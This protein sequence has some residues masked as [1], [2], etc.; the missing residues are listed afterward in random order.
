MFFSKSFGYAV[1]SILYI[2][3]AKEQQRYVQAEDV[4]LQLNAPRHF[5][6]KILKMLAKEQVLLS[7]KGPNGGFRLHQQAEQM[8]LLKI[9]FLT[10]GAKPFEHCVLRV[11]RCNAANP[12]P[13]HTQMSEVKERLKTILA[14][15]TI[16]D[17]LAEEKPAIIRSISFEEI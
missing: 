1:R 2:A 15:T 6:S 3:L 7:V 12:C 10:D 13:M 16:A 11:T 14:K 5:I 4:A 9:Y 8:P 17:L